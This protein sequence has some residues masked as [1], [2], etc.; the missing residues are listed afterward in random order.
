[1]KPTFKEYLINEAGYH[2]WREPQKTDFHVGKV[3]RA[4]QLKRGMLIAV[5]YQS[6]VA[7]YAEVLGFT[8]NDKKYGE[9]GVQYNSQKELLAGN[10][11]KNLKELEELDDKNEYGYHHYMKARDLV[12]KEEG[13]WLYV[14]KGRWSIGSGA[15]KVSFREAK[16]VPGEKGLHETPFDARQ[17]K[18]FL[19]A[20]KQDVKKKKYWPA[21]RRVTQ[22]VKNI[23]PKAKKV[24]SGHY[25]QAYGRERSRSVIKITRDGDGADTLKFLKWVKDK[26][27]PHFP[28]IYSIENLKTNQRPESERNYWDIYDDTHVYA[29]MEKLVPL[30]A[31]KYKWKPEHVPFLEWMFLNDIGDRPEYITGYKKWTKLKREARRKRIY[32]SKLVQAMRM[33]KRLG[34]GELDISLISDE[35]AHNLMVRPSTGEIVIHDPI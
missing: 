27:N 23:S 3:V 2:G 35:R 30:H 13:A 5:S 19:T 32:S 4:S 14:Y 34:D 16:Y 15:D 10:N 29:R 18:R 17:E 6:R 33:V 31:K 25:S 8:G 11:V 12:N 28:K 22:L 20:L 7:F 26:K 9:G 21:E 24:G 1:M